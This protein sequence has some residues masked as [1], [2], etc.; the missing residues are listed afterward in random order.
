MRGGGAPEQPHPTSREWV[1]TNT[2]DEKKAWWDDFRKEVVRKYK[3]HAI[4]SGNAINTA[5]S[6]KQHYFVNR[7]AMIDDNGNLVDVMDNE[8][9]TLDN[10]NSINGITYGRFSEVNAQDCFTKRLGSELCEDLG[11]ATI[12]WDDY[13]DKKVSEYLEKI[14]SI[15]NNS[16]EMPKVRHRHVFLGLGNDK[17]SKTDGRWLK[18]YINLGDNTAWGTLGGT[19]EERKEALVKMA[20]DEEKGKKLYKLLKIKGKSFEDIWEARTMPNTAQP[21]AQIPLPALN[22]A[23][24]FGANTLTNTIPPVVPLQIG[25]FPMVTMPPQ[26]TKQYG[27]VLVNNRVVCDCKKWN[28]SPCVTRK[29]NK[30]FAKLFWNKRD[31]EYVYGNDASQSPANL[32]FV[33]NYNNNNQIGQS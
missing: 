20:K 5:R 30:F 18:D 10:N 23:E 32:N 12:K 28:D 24:G 19:D 21:P 7:Y 25:A 17:K 13:K 4:T 33:N 8:S 3:E 1:S 27:S 9:L 14:Y 29:I 16:N 6:Y 31:Y 2:I 15:L 22:N 11:V 26:V